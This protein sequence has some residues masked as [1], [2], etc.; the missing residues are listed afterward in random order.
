MSGVIPAG[1]TLKGYSAVREG[2]LTAARPASHT[3]SKLIHFVRHAEGHHNVAGQADFEE[4]KNEKYEDAELSELGERQCE[5]L[6]SASADFIQGCLEGKR[7]E[8]VVTSILR[9][10]LQTSSLCFPQLKGKLPWVATELCREQTGQ[11]PCDRRRPLSETTANSGFNHISFD[12]IKSETDPLYWN[13][14]NGDREPLEACIERCE[15][16]LDWLWDREE[17]E[18][19]VCTHSAILAHLIPLIERGGDTFQFFRNA[20]MRSYVVSKSGE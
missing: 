13:W 11:H 1:V 5:A 14:N 17:V 2:Q 18:I 16:F 4:Y 6:K 9:R 8:L 3:G 7:A 12:E 10:C 15:Q 19:I 20:E